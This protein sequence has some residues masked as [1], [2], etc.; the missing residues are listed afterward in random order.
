MIL[1][2]VFKSPDILN[3]NHQYPTLNIYITQQ[4]TAIEYYLLSVGYWIF[5]PLLLLILGSKSSVY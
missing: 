4:V 2:Y 3:K 5:P 1:K